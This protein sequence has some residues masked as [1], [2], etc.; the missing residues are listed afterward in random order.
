M[1]ENFFTTS[2]L[3]AAIR[4][5]HAAHLT[6]LTVNNSDDT[7]ASQDRSSPPTSTVSL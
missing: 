2:N 5:R 7:D 4:R 3:A 6:E 1:I